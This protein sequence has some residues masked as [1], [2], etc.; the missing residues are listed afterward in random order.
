MLR[1]RGVG[2]T[3]TAD[4]ERLHSVVIKQKENLASGAG[5]WL[6][7]KSLE[8]KYLLI[9]AFYLVCVSF[10]FILLLLGKL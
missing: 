6:R 4:D 2:I 5:L 10:N 1:D 3:S 7:K 9:T 8:E